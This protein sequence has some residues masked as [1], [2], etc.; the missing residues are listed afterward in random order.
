M[1]PLHVTEQLGRA[2]ARLDLPDLGRTLPSY[3]IS[4]RK[5]WINYRITVFIRA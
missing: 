4:L 2:N 5:H 3:G 1:D